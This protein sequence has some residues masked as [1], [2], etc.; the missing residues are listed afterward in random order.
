MNWQLLGMEGISII[1]SKLEICNWFIAF[2]YDKNHQDWIS[3]V[4][5]EA[6]IWQTLFMANLVIFTLFHTCLS[7][8]LSLF[9]FFFVKN[10]N[11]VQK[12]VIWIVMSFGEGK[13]LHNPGVEIYLVYTNCENFFPQVINDLERVT[14]SYEWDMKEYLL[15]RIM[16]N[17]LFI[18]KMKKQVK[19]AFFPPITMYLVV[20]RR[21]YLQQQ[22]IYAY[23]RTG[24]R[25][26][27]PT[28]LEVHV[29]S[30]P[31]L[32]NVNS[33]GSKIFTDI[34]TFRGSHVWWWQNLDW[35]WPY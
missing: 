18:L 34:I 30:W 32:V 12:W 15:G 23:E 11:S 26:C 21:W 22:Q 1:V 27:P 24:R 20:L 31:E 13:S 28:P 6:W 29:H 10:T 7:F 17:A 16:T 4:Y 9:F 3:H 35:W 25:Q 5:K 19:T 14:I 2:L 8:S 33:F